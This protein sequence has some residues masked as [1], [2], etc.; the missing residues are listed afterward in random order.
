IMLPEK[1]AVLIVG[2]GIAGLTASLLFA[3]YGI[4]SL[5]IERHAG[6]SIHPRARGVNVRSMEIYR[7]LGLEEKIREVGK[8]LQPAVGFLKGATLREALGNVVPSEQK[9]MREAWQRAEISPT[10]SSRGTQDLV[11]PILL[12]EARERGSEVSFSTELLSFEQD[13]QGVIAHV[14]DR[15]SGEERTINAAFMIGADGANSAV[16]RILGIELNG[17]KTFGHLLNILFHA[18][19]RAFVEGKEFS[20]CLIERPEMVG[21]LLSIDN[22]DRWTFQ[23]VYH[24]ERGERPEDFPRERCQALLTQAIGLPNVEVE[25]SA[26]LPWTARAYIADTLQQ[27]RV[28]LAGDAAHQV[29]PWS[30]LGA[31]TGIADVHNLVW[32]LAAVLKGVAGSALLDT[33]TVERWPVGR[34]AVDFAVSVTG[35]NGLAK[36]GRFEQNLASAATLLSGSILAGVDYKY[37][38]QAIV[39]EQA[40]DPEAREGDLNG[41]PG[42]RVPHLWLS[43]QGERISTVDLARDSIVLLAGP[44][45]GAWCDAARAAAARLHIELKT[46]RIAPDSEYSDPEQR[47]P[48]LAGIHTDGA[49]LV[50]P[51]GIVAWRTK[52]GAAEP[53]QRLEQVFTT[54]LMLSNHR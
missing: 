49:L 32:K 35:E 54:L 25:V 11:E 41:Q 34:A 24:P 51:D 31:N 33:Y 29:T 7:N 44:D 23:L 2:G 50:R 1:T 14:R 5:L 47:W 26:V 52:T 40:A 16:L 19:L 21:V 15:V 12:Q 27:G 3:R 6:T 39:P 8:E 38:S 43:Y 18:D 4:R 48:E 45:G 13:E 28:F 22:S 9:Q 20:Q 46:Y 37:T 30:G 36:K 42:T 10:P 17:G 53:R